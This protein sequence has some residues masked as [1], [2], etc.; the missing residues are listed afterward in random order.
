MSKSA[1]NEVGERCPVCATD[2]RRATRAS[3][4]TWVGLDCPGCGF[5]GMFQVRARQGENA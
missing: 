2:L 1:T 4:G 3:V 5:E